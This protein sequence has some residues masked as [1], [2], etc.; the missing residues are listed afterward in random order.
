MQRSGL[1]SK[2]ALFSAP[3]ALA[4]WAPLPIRLIVGFGFVAHGY[5]KLSRGPE[6][7]GVVLQTL[8]VP[9]PPVLAWLTTLVELVGGAAVLVGAFI[10]L[11]SV[12]MA[13]VLLTA[14]FTVHAQ[15]GFF[16]VK[17]TEVT[18]DSIKFGPVGYEIILLYLAGLAM[19]V[20]GGPG[21]L[22]LDTVLR[23][24]SR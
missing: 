12:P 24:R 13:I 8:G 2:V 23:R 18:A 17:F 19:L 15:Y 10:P 21:W 11:V 20:V 7:F 22:S 3:R 6:T 4:V 14:L 9:M 16:S 5:A 1:L